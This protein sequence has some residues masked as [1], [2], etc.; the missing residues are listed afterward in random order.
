MS[1]IE[2]AVLSQQA[3]SRTQTGS[4]FAWVI[5]FVSSLFFFYEFLLA[6]M[7]NT[8]APSLESSFHVTASRLGI[9]SAGY[10]WAD[11]LFL[12]PAGLLLDRFSTRKII[13]IA[14][15]LCVLTTAGFAVSESL[16]TAFL[17][18]FLSG[19]G[20]AF[21]FL[22]CI[23]LAARWFPPTRLALAVGVIVTIAM[24]GGMS[25]QTP[26]TLAVQAFGWR[27]ALLL[28][29]ALG[30]VFLLLIMVFIRDYPSADGKTAHHSDK[31]ILQS[32]GFWKSIGLALQNRQ[33]W[34]GGLYT[35]LMNLPLVLFG[36]IYGASYLH[37]VR[38]VTE[39]EASWIIS[40]LFLGTIIGSPVMGWFSDRI[41]ERVRPM[42]AGA[43][44]S[45]ALVLGVLY[46]PHLSLM[47]LTL[48]F[49]LVGFVTS[50]QVLAYPLVAAS[51]P[52]V[53]TGSSVGLASVIIMSGYAIFQPVCGILM[54][55]HWDGTMVNDV[56]FYSLA[57][58]RLAFLLIPI[59]FIIS[60][61]VTLF[62]RETH[63]HSETLEELQH[64]Y[65]RSHDL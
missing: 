33:N 11:V 17:F 47:S 44:I 29:A 9:L 27:H 52:L 30:L 51:N 19:I 5:C 28:N 43:V 60:F 53:L 57:D 35:N 49:F 4:W 22:S 23:R 64:E 61:I 6:N 65:T 41:A 32:I 15:S 10:F 34:L 37:Q 58:Y 1:S 62:L 18:R 12:F 59:G 42:R 25:A 50:T 2:S 56:P 21:S 40:T 14:M 3:E 46:V 13:L 45:I 8:I 39:E 63:C 26:L 31:Q 48:L 55:L 16:Q 36:A 54:D 38:G 24:V 7:F 20:N